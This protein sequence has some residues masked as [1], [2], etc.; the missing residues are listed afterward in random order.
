M[1]KSLNSKSNSKTKPARKNPTAFITSAPKYLVKKLKPSVLFSRRPPKIIYIALIIIGLAVLASYKKAWFVAATVN[2]A[3]ITNLEVLARL[4][5][6][7]RTQTLTQ[8]TN[9]KII[10]D[11]AKKKGVAVTESDIDNKIVQLEQNVGGKEMLDS[12]LAQQGQDRK[13]LREQLKIQ[14][15]IEKMYAGEASISAEEI[16]QFVAQNQDQMQSTDSA[17]QAEEAK[18]VLKQQKLGQIFNSKFQQLK[19]QAKVTIF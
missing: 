17:K 4:N 9:E 1:P 10:L 6:Q 15:S 16:D 11:E 18:E 3:P 12:L 19:Q 2:G 13:S 5:E 14:I 7:Y 8:M